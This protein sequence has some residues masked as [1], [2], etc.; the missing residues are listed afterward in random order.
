MK[1]DLVV[2]MLMGVMLFVAV[3]CAPTEAQ[4]P[5]PSDTPTFYRLVPGTY[6]NPW[7]RF[8]ITYPKE[9]VET[10]GV[11][12]QVFRAKPPGKTGNALSVALTG[13]GTLDK[14]V[15]GAAGLFRI[16]GVKEVT[17]VKDYPTQLSN[18]V[19]A[20]E[21]EIRGARNGLP[22]SFACLAVK[23]GDDVIFVSV[24]SQS[25]E[26][27]DLKAILYSLRYE[28]QRDEPVKVPPT[29]ERSSTA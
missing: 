21:G 29:C 13:P 12:F 19:P 2:S 18:G 1:K 4:S 11:T 6:V 5:A 16:G 15:D 3:P 27:E 28:P 9:W 22:F 25:G 7:P 26:L 8:T 14:A 17:I 23:H 24:E 10:L 20:R